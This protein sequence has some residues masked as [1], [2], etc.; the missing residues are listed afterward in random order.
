MTEHRHPPRA[1][2]AG[3]LALLA[4]VWLLAMVTSARF[5]VGDSPPL[6]PVTLARIALEFPQ[7]VAATLVAGAAIGLAAVNLLGRRA[8]PV[9]ERAGPR[10]A[11]SAA[12]GLALGTAL[13]VVTTVGYGTLPAVGELSAT[14]AATGVL[15]G[16]LAGVRHRAVLAAGVAGA[17]AVFAVRFVAGVFDADLQTLFGA[18]D[19]AQSVLTASTWVVLSIAVVAG[20]AGGVT[21]YVY[22]RRGGPPGVGWPGYLMAGAVPGLLALLAE[23]ATQVGG[24]RLF[25]LLG[26]LSPDERLVQEFLTT[27]RLN[28]ALV[29]LF[30]GALVAILLLGRTLPARAD[31]PADEADGPADEAD[32]PADEADGPADEET[33]S[34][35]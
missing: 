4:L 22:L 9:L 24:A 21:G 35:S 26:E 17:L 32:G 29:V 27:T 25:Q 31:G 23:V 30:V 6:T 8:R 5:T 3:T 34:T 1:P 19:T 13:A 11:V 15:G 14:L 18:R 12:A 20:A 28:H 33:Q 10:L 16:L 2:G 7:L